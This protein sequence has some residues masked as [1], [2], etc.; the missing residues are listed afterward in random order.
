MKKFNNYIIEKNNNKIN[1]IKDIKE[2]LLILEKPIINGLEI[3]YET[4]E[5]G[6]YYITEIHQSNVGISE[7]EEIP[8]DYNYNY[9]YDYS[10][11]KY[12]Q[13]FELSNT[14]L[15]EI[16]DEIDN[17]IQNETVELATLTSAI[18]NENFKQIIYLI[19][20]DLDWFIEKKKK[21][22][23]SHYFEVWLSDN[24]KEE[25]KKLYPEKYNEYLLHK[26]IDKF[27]I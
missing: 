25:I 5:Y 8:R 24:Q 16:Y 6:E 13:Y 23:F 17:R 27:N 7:K 20:L 21:K 1:I 3:E 9:V 18:L 2:L 26:N 12:I 15:L 22:S 4:E 19:G 11:K 10:L 14:N